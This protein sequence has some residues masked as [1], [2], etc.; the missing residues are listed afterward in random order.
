MKAK[1]QL[2]IILLAVIVMS[3]TSCQNEPATTVNETTDT[4]VRPRYG[5][6]RI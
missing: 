4:E 3:M 1:K 6:A 2:S 5:N